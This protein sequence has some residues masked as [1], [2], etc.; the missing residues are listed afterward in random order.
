MS[1]SKNNQLLSA[2]ME[3]NDLTNIKEFIN[4]ANSRLDAITSITNNSH[5]I[6]ADAVTSMICEN[7]DSINSKIS[8]NTTNKMSVCLR[9]GE[10]ILRIVTYLLI[11]NDE[12]VLEKSCL[13]DLK[14]TYL[15]LGVPLR[16]ARR[17]IEL[18]REA[19]I[20]DLNS[21]VN[22]MK[23]NKDFLPKLISETKYQFERI[24]NLLN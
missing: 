22:N 5:A 21:T 3:L 7:Q 14:N 11:S 8:L 1:V 13:K 19:T 10:I 24:T 23:G 18:M 2:E 20:S 17:V 9:D 12:S 16:N 6:A 4:S 15:A